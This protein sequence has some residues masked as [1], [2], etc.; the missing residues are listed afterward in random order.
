M[1]FGYQIKHMGTVERCGKNA[2]TVKKKITFKIFKYNYK[3]LCSFSNLGHVDRLFHHVTG[4][5]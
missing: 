1:Y 5:N 2:T 3:L 4:E